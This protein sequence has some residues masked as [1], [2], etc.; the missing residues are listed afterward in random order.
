M[1]E[2]FRKMNHS[3]VVLPF[4]FL[5]TFLLWMDG[6]D[7]NRMSKLYIGCLNERILKFDLQKL[8]TCKK[9]KVFP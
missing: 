1:V 3:A 8:L 4:P 6:L 9:P 2:E 5:A 7:K